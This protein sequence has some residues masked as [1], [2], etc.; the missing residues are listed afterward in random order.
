MT[1]LTSEA[2][3]EIVSKEVGDA[4]ENHEAIKAF[5]DA[6]KAQA[7]A[8]GKT[9]EQVREIVGG[10]IKALGEGDT[11]VLKDLSVG[12][13]ADGGYIVPTEFY[14]QL[15]EKKYKDAQ[16]RKYAT[17]IPMSSDKIEL[18][19]ESSTVSVNWTT[20]LAAITQSDPTFALVTLACNML[21]GISRQSRQVL[22]D[23]GLNEALQDYIIRIFG[24]A[25]A[26]AEDTAFMVGSGTAQPK[27]IYQ[28]TFTQTVA[29]GAASLVD[30]D[31]TNLEY[32]LPRQYRSNA[33]FIMHDTRKKL[34][35]NLRSTDGK[36]LH[37]EIDNKENPTLNGYP[38]VIQD[39][40]PTN[41]GG[42][43]NE[44]VVFF[45]DLSYYYIGDR[46][47]VFTEVSTQEGTSFEKHRAA[48]KVGER[49]D[50]QLTLATAFAT[51]TA[52]K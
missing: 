8:G 41:L 7:L 9:D 35:S 50:G 46:Q 40:I 27:G 31:I 43:T 10:F 3:A 5:S 34:I 14:K 25:L 44:S 28:Y 20:E 4:L 47:Q 52:V 22:A 48:I 30:G 12:V 1:E 33:V 36:K 11:A 45:G 19:V 16:I 32:T 51:L 21:A 49:L 42:G 37:P 38:V 6:H 17:V 23:A 18:P 2:I 39:D 24:R 29:Q 26:L 15:I 13:D